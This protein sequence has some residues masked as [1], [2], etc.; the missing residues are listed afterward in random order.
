VR[1]GRLDLVG[2]LH[3]GEASPWE[4]ATEWRRGKR[5]RGNLPM[6]GGSHLVGV[7]NSRMDLLSC[8]K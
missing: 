7:G 6:I 8:G 4:E 2:G 3:R 1:P 5:K